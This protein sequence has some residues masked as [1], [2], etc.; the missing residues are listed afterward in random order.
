MA[1]GRALAA[2]E[3]AA[4]TPGACVLDVGRRDRG[5]IPRNRPVPGGRRVAGGSQHRA[6]TL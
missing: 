3:F 4:G 2:A 6:G 1:V 5:G